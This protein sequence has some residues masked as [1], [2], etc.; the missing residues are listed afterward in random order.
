MMSQPQDISVSIDL[1]SFSDLKFSFTA[2]VAHHMSKFSNDVAMYG[3]R[4][5]KFGNFY[6]FSQI[7]SSINN[8]DVVFSIPMDSYITNK[9][10]DY[11]RPHIVRAESLHPWYD[12]QPEIFNNLLFSLYKDFFGRFLTPDTIQTNK[13]LTPSNTT[14]PKEVSQP[15]TYQKITK[16]EE[17]HRET[18]NFSKSSD[19]SKLERLNPIGLKNYYA[20]DIDYQQLF[21]HCKMR[22]FKE[23]NKIFIV[24][25]KCPSF[26]TPFSNFFQR[27]GCRGGES[28][29]D[30]FKIW[31][32]KE[33]R[34]LRLI[35]VSQNIYFEILTG[36]ILYYEDS[37]FYYSGFA[38]DYISRDY[39][40]SSYRYQSM[41]SHMHYV[42]WAGE[43]SFNH[44]RIGNSIAKFLGNF[45]LQH[46]GRFDIKRITCYNELIISGIFRTLASLPNS[47]FTPEN[48]NSFSNEYKSQIILSICNDGTLCDGEEIKNVVTFISGVKDFL[49]TPLKIV[50]S[51][52]DTDY[53]NFMGLC[54]KYFLN[55][56]YE[57][58]H[59]S[60]PH[61]YIKNEHLKECFEVVKNIIPLIGT[62]KQDDLSI[63]A[64][65]LACKI[66][67]YKNAI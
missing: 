25:G 12:I 59:H 32:L 48:Y 14:N 36:L 55:Q 33:V 67:N 66:I 26:T 40:L 39:E 11:I 41:F 30:K 60:I 34:V 35:P 21:N 19:K 16:T 49:E 7:T 4:H 37:K 10:Y 28:W 15:S 62:C 13:P 52:N 5:H 17:I 46:Y 50:A 54:V 1:P 22:P 3:F 61:H 43:F 29:F 51:S 24:E 38:L 63:L 53:L 27:Q 44:E 9:F 2:D 65:D 18:Q 58:D 57:M 64:N 45:N 42:P 6:R 47:Y 56:L 31:I 23:H 8:W 20:C